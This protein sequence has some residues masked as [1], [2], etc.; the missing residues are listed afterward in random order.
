MIHIVGAAAVDLVATRRHPFLPG[1]SNPAAIRMAPGGVGCRIFRA[2]RAGRRLITALGDDPLSGW[3][4]EALRREGPVRVKRA[5]GL[6]A[7]LYLALMESGRRD[8]AP[9]RVVRAEDSTG[10][11]DRLLAALLD[12]LAAGRPVEE[13]LP[14]AMREVEKAL[15]EGSL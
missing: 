1:T 6:P 9:G 10:A 3:L 15:E 14:Q 7:P 4:E 12:G 2:L 8:Y 11:G 5:A 13:A